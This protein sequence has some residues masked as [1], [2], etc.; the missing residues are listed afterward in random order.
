MEI[1]SFHLKPL[2]FKWYDKINISN[3]NNSKPFPESQIEI[4]INFSSNYFIKIIDYPIISPIYLLF[5]ITIF[6]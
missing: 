2:L 6:W 5:S 3:K 1:V 4:I